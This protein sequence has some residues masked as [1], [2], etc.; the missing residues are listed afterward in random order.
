[1]ASPF[2]IQGECRHTQLLGPPPRPALQGRAP[3]PQ[4]AEPCIQGKRTRRYRHIDGQVHIGRHGLR[5]QEPARLP[6]AHRQLSDR[7]P[8]IQGIHGADCL[9]HRP[10][11]P[12]R[13]EVLRG[14]GLD[15]RRR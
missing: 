7:L 11:R 10:Q 3:L 5:Q 9:Y 15:G 1:M 6:G 13:R 8:F 4:Q 2:E 14:A 12:H